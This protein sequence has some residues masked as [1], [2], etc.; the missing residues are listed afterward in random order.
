LFCEVSLKDTGLR[1]SFGGPGGRFFR[2]IG[3]IFRTKEF[4]EG[5]GKTTLARR[6]F[7]ASFLALS[8]DPKGIEIQEKSAH[9]KQTSPFGQSSRSHLTAT[10]INQNT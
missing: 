8:K 2:W 10:P 6:G 9:E 4:L 1:T 5:T 3:W 7:R